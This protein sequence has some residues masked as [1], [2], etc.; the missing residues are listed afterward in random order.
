[1]PHTANHS[2]PPGSPLCG[3]LARLP[4]DPENLFVYGSLLFPEVLQVLLGRVPSMSPVVVT[5]VALLPYLAGSI[6]DS[7]TAT[8]RHT[9]N[10]SRT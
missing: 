10:S 6:P 4:E 2:P 7:Y 5:G 9:G 8:V 3:R 1:M